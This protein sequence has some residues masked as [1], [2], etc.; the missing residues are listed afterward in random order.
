MQPITLPETIAS[1]S[2]LIQA[3]EQIREKLARETCY[4]KVCVIGLG[5][6]GLPTAGLLASSGFLVHGVD[7]NRK[8]IE[9]LEKKDLK[10]LEP[11]LKEILE[12]AIKSGNF[13]FSFSPEKSDVFIVAVPTPFSQRYKPDISFVEAG[14]LAIAPFLNPGNLVI[15]E[16]TIPVGTTEKMGELLK[17]LRPDLF[18]AKRENEKNTSN[19]QGEQVL[20]AH[21][22]ERVLPGN[23]LHELVHNARVV[24]GINLHSGEAARRFYSIFSKG[25]I[26]VTDS[27]TAELCKLVENSFRDVNIAFANELS[28]ICDKLE[29]DV[30]ELID[31]ANH[32]PRVNILKPGPGVGGHCIAVDPWFIVDSCPKE[33][34]LIKMARKVNNHKPEHVLQ[35]ILKEAKKFDNPIV[36]S[37]GI[38]YK[39]NTNDARESP[40]VEIIKKLAKQK[41]GEILLVE[42][43]IEE[44]PKEL[45]KLGMQ[46]VDLDFAIE[47]ANIIV[48]LV[49]HYAFFSITQTSLRGKVLIDTRGLWRSHTT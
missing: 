45:K 19:Q 21:C 46:K 31:L 47:K 22:P 23:L 29:I 8:V 35:K 25:K 34:Q 1:K 4:K 36:A 39:A 2:S 38:S 48:L 17:K 18:I 42:P 26:L 7:V 40:A 27:R 20:L 41:I 12:F 37:L 43:Y 28:M 24:G 30:W 10:F 5:Y 44:L 15:L 3:I 33:A 49:D 6:I 9:T 13:T 14:V 11:G 32:H 16:S